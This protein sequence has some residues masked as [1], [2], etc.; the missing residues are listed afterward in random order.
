MKKII[1]ELLT[2]KSVRKN[3]ALT[4]LVVTEMDAGFPWYG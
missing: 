2:N 3:T 1:K 4:A